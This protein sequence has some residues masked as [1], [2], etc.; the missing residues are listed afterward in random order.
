MMRRVRTMS[1]TR[2]LSGLAWLMLTSAAL[3]ADRS[4]L[5]PPQVVTASPGPEHGLARRAF[6]GIPSLARGPEGRLWAVWYASRTGGEDQNNYVVVATSGD[7]GESW[8]D[9]ALAIDPDRDG[10]VRAF[11]P[12]VWLDPDG[13]LWVFW[14][15]AIGHDG[16]VAGVWTVTTES[17]DDPA[18]R[19]SKPRRLTDGIMMGKPTVLSTGEWMLPASTWRRTDHSA[20]VVVSSDSG[21]T[22]SVRGGCQI[23]PSMRV[24]DE[25]MIVERRDDAL[26]M[27][28]R[29]NTGRLLESVSRDRGRTWPV[30]RPGSIEHPSARF[31][32]RRLASGRLLL[33]KHHGTRARKRLT[34]LLSGD[35]GAT[36]SDGLLLD[37]RGTVS[38][39]DGV[40]A[41]D[42]RI[43]IIYDRNRTSDREILMAIF[44][45]EDVA[46]GRPGEGCRLRVEVSRAAGAARSG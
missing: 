14:A 21:K 34:A 41:E 5:E 2:C 28:A 13:R 22:W 26:W 24:F 33:V 10:P 35:D 8:T 43:Y 23:P 29:S 1:R 45:E 16:S 44:T 4:F 38:Y 25:H 6:Q 46:R 18:P 37:E 42:G 17:P 40:Q 12:Q 39:P 7:D 30:A 32:I 15:Q 36:W 27:L 11:D 31:F 9:P 3:A 20:R 19:W